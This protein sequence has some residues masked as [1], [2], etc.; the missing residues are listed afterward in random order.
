MCCYYDPSPRGDNPHHVG[1]HEKWDLERR[2]EMAD[3]LPTLPW[4]AIHYKVF[5]AANHSIEEGWQFV[6]QHLRPQDTVCIGHYLGD[7]PSMIE[8]NVATL[9]GLA[10]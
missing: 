3:F 8:E 7:N 5:A 10:G 4:P 6:A 2:Q 1:G 9:E